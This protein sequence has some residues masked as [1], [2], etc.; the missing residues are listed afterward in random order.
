MFSS[1]LQR[2][3]DKLLFAILG[4]LQCGEIFL[5]MPDGQ[6]HQ[7]SGPSKGPKADLKIHSKDAF[8]AF[9]V[10]GKWGF[11]RRLWMGS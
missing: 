7:F 9:S 8:A 4:N 11:A 6:Q 2:H 10:M 1:F 5:T 3:Q